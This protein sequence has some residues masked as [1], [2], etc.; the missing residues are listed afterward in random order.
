MPSAWRTSAASSTR[1]RAVA[2]RR[3]GARAADE[4]AAAQPACLG[5]L[6]ECGASVDITTAR[7]DSL[8]HFAVLANSEPCGARRRCAAV[9]PAAFIGAAAVRLLIE[10]NAVVDALNDANLSV[11][12]VAERKAPNLVAVRARIAWIRAIGF[13]CALYWIRLAWI[14]RCAASR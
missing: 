10:R 2:P 9:A 6:L 5:V 14:D 1:W 13:D 8:L 7:K 4:R 12:D 11:L 3:A